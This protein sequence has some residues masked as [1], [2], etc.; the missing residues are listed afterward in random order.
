[1]NIKSG[2]P[3]KKVVLEGCN[4][5]WAQERYLP[6][7]VAKAARGDIELWAI[8]IG[9]EI[10]L[11][12][13]EIKKSWEVAQNYDK[14]H[15][16][17]KIKNEQSYNRFSDATYVFIVTPDQYHCQIAEFWLGRLAPEGKI[18]IEKPLDAFKKSALKLR[19]NIKE[20]ER[21]DAVFMFSHYLATAYPFLQDKNRSLDQIGKVEKIEF[22]ILESSPIPPNRV[23]T[24]NKGIIFDVFGH[25]L[26]LSGA[27]VERNL[28]PSKSI[29]QRVKLR[30]VKAARYLDCP[31]AG[32]TFSRI[33]FAFNNIE[34]VSLIGKGIGT[35]DDKV[36]IVYGTNGM[37]ELDFLSEAFRI[38]NRQ[39][40]Q[41]SRGQLNSR[42]VESFLEEIIGKEEQPISIPGVLDFDAAIEMLVILDEAKMRIEKILDYQAGESIDSILDRL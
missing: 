37:S 24:L 30:E 23:K 2:Y 18:F 19:Q 26:A 27:L 1:M 13:P 20:R 11:K 17:N 36:T 25:V 38:F 32:E 22:H 28:T 7:L 34:V 16:L 41:Q 4:G 9:D 42:H 40:Q 15:Y 5:E 14:A 6:F 21:E 35:Q 39:G 8:D 10:Q 3:N 33:K 12:N 31:I 29:L